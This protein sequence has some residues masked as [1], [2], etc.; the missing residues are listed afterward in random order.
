MSL[1]TPSHQAHP[2]TFPGP[3]VLTLNA[4]LVENG[5]EFQSDFY[6]KFKLRHAKV[7]LCIDEKNSISKNY[8]FP[9]LYGDVTVSIAM[10][11]CSLEAARK[12]MPKA[13][14]KPVN[15]GL[16]RSLVIISTYH[17]AKVRGIAPYNEIGMSIP[18]MVGA[19]QLLPAL[20]LLLPNKS[21]GYYVFSMPVTTL[22]NKIRGLK[23]WGLPKVV[24]EI[25]LHPE[26]DEYVTVAND[27]VGEKYLEL[28]VP[29]NGN[30]T[31]TNQG[32]TLYSVKDEAIHRSTSETFGNF[33]ITKF[34]RTI[35]TKGITP[36]Q[37][38]L[39]IGSGP[40]AKILRDLT[41]EPQP[42]QTRFG[43]HISS[44]FD[45]PNSRLENQKWQLENQ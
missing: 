38:Y 11:F 36:K 13:E 12:L 5:Q 29:T 19:N 33:A 25:N 27:S 40:S 7:P 17:Y 31:P 8:F 21:L 16:G 3:P 22:E 28:R 9:T 30:I 23:L 42:F 20:P 1:S 44:T 32:T 15:M 24:Q 45:L 43:T 14:M 41:I 35:L 26:G 39:W 4:D 34:N 2:G 6:R 37:N 10:F 18:V